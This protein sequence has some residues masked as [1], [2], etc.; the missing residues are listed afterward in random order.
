MKIPGTT[1]TVQFV[2]IDTVILTGLTD[3]EDRTLP[4]LGPTSQT[5]ADQQWVWIEKTLQESTADWIIVA[6]HYPGLCN[7]I[8]HMYV[9]VIIRHGMQCFMNCK[10]PEAQGSPPE[11]EEH[12]YP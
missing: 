8:T 6:G 4:P 10:R 9:H 2:F 3:P 12:A 1:S 7:T 5:R 11:G